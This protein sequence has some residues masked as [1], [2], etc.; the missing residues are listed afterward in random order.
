[1]HTD[2]ESDGEDST[3]EKS[4]LFAKLNEMQKAIAGY[5]E[6]KERAKSP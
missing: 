6:S 5:K 2:Q 1:V 3:V 4:Q